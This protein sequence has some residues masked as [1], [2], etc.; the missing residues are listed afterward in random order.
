MKSAL[1]I[2]IKLTYYKL[3]K[4][5]RFQTGGIKNGEKEITV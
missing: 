5:K 1:T 4:C 2:F 3:T